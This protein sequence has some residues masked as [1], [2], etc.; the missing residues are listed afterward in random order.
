M[1]KLYKIILGQKGKWEGDETEPQVHRGVQNLPRGFFPRNGLLYA[2]LRGG[3]RK[4]GERDGNS[5][6]TTATNLQG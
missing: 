2:S 1:G 5:N 4:Q 6:E 3:K